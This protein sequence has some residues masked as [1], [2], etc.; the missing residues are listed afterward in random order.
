MRC[1]CLLRHTLLAVCIFECGIIPNRLPPGGVRYLAVCGRPEMTEERV[2][3]DKGERSV[4][5]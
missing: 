3:A 4:L 1:H 5:A 2:R